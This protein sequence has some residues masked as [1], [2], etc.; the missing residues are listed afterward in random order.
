M[1]VLRKSHLLSRTSDGDTLPN[2]SY[3]K[4]Y[5]QL[6]RHKLDLLKALHEYSQQDIPVVKIEPYSFA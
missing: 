1:N 6:S 4:Q 2:N 5:K 3:I